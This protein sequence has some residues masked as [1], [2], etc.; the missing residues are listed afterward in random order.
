MYIADTLQ[1]VSENLSK[2]VAISS[3]GEAESK[4]IGKRFDDILNPK[5]EKIYKE[6]ETTN[7]IR[8]KLR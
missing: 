1:N 7:R 5:P 2:L 4:Y 6:G 3:G 8:Q